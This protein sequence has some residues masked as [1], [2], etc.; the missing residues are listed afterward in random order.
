[1]EINTESSTWVL[2]KTCGIQPEHVLRNNGFTQKLVQIESRY[3][4]DFKSQKNKKKALK[5]FALS[6]VAYYKLP[7]PEVL[8][9]ECP[10]KAAKKADHY[11]AAVQQLAAKR[12][13]TVNPPVKAQENDNKNVAKLARSLK[14]DTS[15]PTGDRQEDPALRPVNRTEQ[16]M[17]ACAGNFYI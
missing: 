8:K 7:M 15:S 17:R 4:S 9:N 14:V 11:R 2:L 3:G 10:R 1:M 5:R 12:Q 13:S 6:L 16:A